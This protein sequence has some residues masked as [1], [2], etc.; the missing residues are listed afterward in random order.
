VSGKADHVLPLTRIGFAARGLPAYSLIE[1]RY[2][3]IPD[4]RVSHR[5]AGAFA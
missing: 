5:V 4:P 2:R 1:A 3:I